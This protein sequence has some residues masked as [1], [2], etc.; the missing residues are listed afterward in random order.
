[1]WEIPGKRVDIGRFQ[2][3]QPVDVLYEFDGPRIFTLNYAEGELNLG[4]WSDEDEQ[5]SR[6][7]VVPTTTKILAALHKGSISVFEAL[8]QPRCWLCDVGHSGD[9]RECRRVE[10]DAIPRDSLPAIR[11]TLL[12]TLEPQRVDLEGRVR[13]LDKDRM[14]FELREI[15]GLGS[16]LC[17]FDESLR[18]DVYQSFDDEIRVKLAG[19]KYPEKN[20]VVGLGIS[21]IEAKHL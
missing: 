19:W 15:N 8:N 9:L 20:V 21:R 3:F 6:Y 10:F 4:Y 2:P 12:P 5:C 7:V 1:M 11:A 17:E 16:Q 14:S 13:E 18:D